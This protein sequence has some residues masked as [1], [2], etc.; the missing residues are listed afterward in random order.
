MAGKPRKQ[1]STSLNVMEMKTKNHS[2]IP[3]RIHRKNYKEKDRQQLPVR[4]WR[5]GPLKRCWREGKMMGSLWKTVWQLLEKSNVKLV[6]YPSIPL[7]SIYS[8]E[9]KTCLFSNVFCVQVHTKTCTQEFTAALFVIAK[10]GNKL[11]VPSWRRHAQNVM[12]PRH[13]H[14]LATKRKEG[15]GLAAVRM[16]LEN[17]RPSE[18]NQTREPTC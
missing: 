9:V 1:C 5:R 3:L 6:R 11:K 7:L 8:R 2:E 10:G 4:R 13:G 17:V 16:S 15:L 14:Y 12:L 18:S